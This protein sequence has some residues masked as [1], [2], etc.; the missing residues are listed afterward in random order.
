MIRRPPRSTLFPYTTL[1]RSIGDLLARGMVDH[2]MITAET[3]DVRLAIPGTDQ[4]IAAPGRMRQIGRQD[5]ERFLTP[6]GSGI[7]ATEALQKDIETH[8]AM[9]H[10]QR[11]AYPQVPRHPP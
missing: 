3:I 9:I 2:Q 10:Q 8:Q 4:G 7:P 1:F 6:A 5:P 11:P